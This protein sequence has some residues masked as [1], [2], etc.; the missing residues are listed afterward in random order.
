M[1][2]F[3][4]GV[5]IMAVLIEIFGEGTGIYIG[6]TAIAGGCFLI[7]YLLDRS[8]VFRFI[9]S[10]SLIGFIFALPFL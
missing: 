10:F 7:M 3:G 8:I 9:F 5:A 4:L 6:I 1:F 2:L